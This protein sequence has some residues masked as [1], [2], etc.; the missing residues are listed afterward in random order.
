MEV[1]YKMVL[2]NKAVVNGATF[3][4][5]GL[6]ILALSFALEFQ[7]KRAIVFAVAGYIYIVASFLAF[8]FPRLSGK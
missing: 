6:A 7:G 2:F 5:V 8:V 4:G 1:K 3:F